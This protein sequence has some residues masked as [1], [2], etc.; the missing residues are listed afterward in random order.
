MSK[1]ITW[2]HKLKNRNWWGLDMWWWVS[3]CLPL[4]HVE[5]ADLLKRHNKLTFPPTLWH[6]LT[7]SA[8]LV[9]CEED[10]GWW[11]ERVICTFCFFGFLPGL[12][13]VARPEI[14]LHSADPCCKNQMSLRNSPMQRPW[15]SHSSVLKEKNRHGIDYRGCKILCV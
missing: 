15:C 13:W 3:F 12:F 1:C 4:Q 2:P 14:C 11:E 5:S 9:V 8:Q 7:F 6:S 10:D